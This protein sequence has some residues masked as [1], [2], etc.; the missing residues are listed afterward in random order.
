MT[1]VARACWYDFPQYYDMAFRDETANE[2]R[3]LQAAFERYAQRP[4]RSVLEAGCG[5]GRLVTA[6]ARKGYMVWAFDCNRHALEYAAR[7][8]A[9][10]KLR[11]HL[12][13][14][15]LADFDLPTPVDAALCTM[16]TFRHLLTEADA[17]CHL[18]RVAHY[19]RAGGIY[20]LGFHL[21]PPDADEHCVER[22]SAR[23]GRLRVTYTLRVLHCDRRKRIE[24]MRI[25]LRVQTP[26]RIWRLQDEFPLRI[27]TADQ[28]RRLLDRVPQW[29]LADVFDFWYQI[30]DPLT[31]DDRLADAVF[32][33]RRRS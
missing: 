19:V 32:V 6:L 18:E 22:W 5:S 14:A 23:R 24:R 2:V 17:R 1:D 7:R 15:D 12:F 16:N 20:V 28:F 10:S 13:Q 3:F 4:V 9:R 29:Q 25:T 27:Y 8:L 31:L 21:L 11:A 26:R 30:D 33:L